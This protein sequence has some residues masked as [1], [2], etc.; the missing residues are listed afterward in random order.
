[1]NDEKVQK[2]LNNSPSD[3]IIL[4]E[5]IDAIFVGRSSVNKNSNVSFSG[6]LNAI[7]GIRSQEGRI[8]ILT[9]NHKEKLDPALLRPGRCDLQ[10]HLN[11]ASV[12]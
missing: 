10:I 6:L 4:M 7:D 8:L 5:D 2:L 11:N 1:L 3:S 12:S 9:T